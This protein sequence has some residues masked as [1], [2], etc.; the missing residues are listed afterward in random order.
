MSK[1]NWIDWL[2][3]GVLGG[4]AAI[5]MLLGFGTGGAAGASLRARGDYLVHI[6]DCTGCHT[7]GTL[8][9]KPDLAAFLSG[10]DIGFRLPGGIFFP[11]NLTPDPRTGI[12]GWSRAE[13]A[14]ALRTGRIPGGR[15]L[16][17]IM[18]WRSF[19]HLTPRDAL[20]IATYL[21]SLPPIRHAVPGPQPPSA[22]ARL[23]AMTLV[24]PGRR[25]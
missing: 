7:P 22:A 12:G 25:P 5:A 14:R 21:K 16:A 15:E 13:I 11:S 20:A 18:P 19:A 4:A 8:S 9:G 24:L 2:S 23:P 3:T 6:M 1:A 17:P 10:S